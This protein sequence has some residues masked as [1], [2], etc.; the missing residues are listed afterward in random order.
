MPKRYC[1]SRAEWRL[2][3]GKPAEPLSPHYRLDCDYGTGVVTCWEDG[4][5][6]PIYVCE[7]HAKQLGT[8]RKQSTDV[9]VITRQPDDGDSPVKVEDQIEIQ[10]AAAGSPKVAASLE[11][12]R[13]LPEVEVGRAADRI[14]IQEAPAADPKASASPEPARALPDVPDLKIGSAMDRAEIQELADPSAGTPAAPESPRGP[15]EVKVARASDSSARSP[16]RDRTYGDSAKAMVD[17]AIWNMATGDYQAYKNA[18]QQGKSAAEA[19]RAA[20]GQL[21]MV[22]RKIGDYT[23][24]LEAV[25]SESKAKISVEEA[26]DKPLEQAVLEIIGN[27]AMSDSEKDAAIQQL[28]V[29]QEWT[30]QGL[31][32]DLTPLQANRIL[33]AIGDRVGWGGAV[34]ISEEL[35]PMH[36]AL[37]ASLKTAIRSAVPKAQNFHD[38]LTNL[39]AAKSDLEVG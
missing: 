4:G 2:Q 10:V 35:K 14:Q 25:L 7:T 5:S 20:G 21:G 6:E 24:K 27:G 16:I 8:P 34:G 9:R 12:A 26:I 28:G 15:A 31:H 17:E 1:T 13:T 38:R 39:Y 18:L 11:P 23:V 29:L 36:R 30:K 33:L 32:G 3:P 37:Y 22:H 19:A